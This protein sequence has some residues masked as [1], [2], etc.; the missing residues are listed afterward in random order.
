M[1]LTTFVMAAM[2]E[3]MMTG[4]KTIVVSAEL[5]NRASEENKEAARNMCSSV[6][7]EMVVK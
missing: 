6:G 1:D 5:F 4:A 7:A 3:A 2:M